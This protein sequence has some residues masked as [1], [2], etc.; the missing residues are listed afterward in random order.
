MNDK[1][2]REYVL[3]EA[4][5]KRL[6]LIAEDMQRPPQRRAAQVQAAHAVPTPH[7]AR[8]LPGIP[9][10]EPVAEETETSPAA[11][12]A[13]T[14]EPA[15][16]E[17]RIKL[18]VPVTDPSG[19]VWTEV[20]LRRPK[21]SKMEEYAG[22]RLVTSGKLTTNSAIIAA[23]AGVPLDFMLDLDGFDGMR[24]LGALTDFFPQDLRDKIQSTT[25]ASE[26]T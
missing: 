3:T 18:E 22:H 17:K 20:V 9:G 13:A 8:V 2:Q 6:G 7:S 21:W 24:L 16:H 4:E 11:V 1:P 23:C 14:G 10:G 12:A 19:K 25:S 5:A 26:Q 15:P